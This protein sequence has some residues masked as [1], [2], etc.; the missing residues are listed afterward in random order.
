MHYLTYLAEKTVLAHQNHSKLLKWME[1][2]PANAEQVSLVETVRAV[3]EQEVEAGRLRY[4]MLHL[5]PDQV[6]SF[7]QEETLFPELE[8][9]C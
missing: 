8:G 2:H 1:D 6:D 4:S 5:Q 7:G 3:L 9:S